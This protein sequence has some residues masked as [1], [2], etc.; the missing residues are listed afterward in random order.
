M[1]KISLIGVDLAKEGLEFTFVEP[2]K[3]CTECRIKNVCFN[4]EPGRTY[5]ITKVRDKENPCFVFNKDKVNTIEVELL[6]D[7]LNVANG[8]KLQE[9]S[10][11]A[12]ESLNCDYI[13]CENIETCNLIHIKEG[14]KAKIL[15]V[16]E[17]VDCPK[18]LNLKRVTVSLK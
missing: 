1:A 12:T 17:K 14:L 6:E 15:S 4:L 5:R 10:T 3:G 2:L 18:G 16:G 9:G 8:R 7:H 13:T 11:L